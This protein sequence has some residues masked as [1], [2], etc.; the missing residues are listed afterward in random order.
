MKAKFLIDQN[1]S[2][3]VIFHLADKFDE[4]NHVKDFNLE[5]ASD[6]ENME[7]CTTK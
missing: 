2:H 7:F 3:R 4:I 5:Y 6:A 1:I